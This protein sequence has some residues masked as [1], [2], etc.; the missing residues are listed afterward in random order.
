MKSNRILLSDRHAH[1]LTL[2]EME[3]GVAIHALHVLAVAFSLEPQYLKAIMDLHLR[4]SQVLD[5]KA[6]EL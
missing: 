1:T 4:L 6:E 5:G 2:T 3:I